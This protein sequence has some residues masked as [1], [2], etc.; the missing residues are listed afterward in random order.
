MQRRV[1]TRVLDNDRGVLRFQVRHENPDAQQR[2]S[3]NYIHIYIYIYIYIYIFLLHLLFGLATSGFTRG[4][5]NLI[6]F[7]LDQIEFFCCFF[8]TLSF[9][10]SHSFLVLATRLTAPRKRACLCLKCCL[11]NVSCRAK[12]KSLTISVRVH[13]SLV[14]T[15]GNELEISYLVIHEYFDKYLY[16]NDIALMKVRAFPLARLLLCVFSLCELVALVEL[17]AEKPRGV[18]REAAPHRIARKAGRK[19]PGWNALHRDWLETYSGKQRIARDSDLPT[20]ESYKRELGIRARKATFYCPDIATVRSGHRNPPF[21]PSSLMPFRD[22]IFTANPVALGCSEQSSQARVRER[23]RLARD[24][25]QSHV[26]GKSTTKRRRET[27]K[28]G[29]SAW[30]PAGVTVARE[31]RGEKCRRKN[32][33][34]SR[35]KFAEYQIG[36]I[37]QQE[38]T[39]G[40][41]CGDHESRYVRVG[42][43]KVQA[44]V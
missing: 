13:T 16:F 18:R 2:A 39:R 27:R 11:A 28:L 25:I 31:R 7:Y 30:T 41:R 8:L 43:A 21:V 34:T 23:Q 1:H 44:A 4:I 15:G 38:S 26:R 37:H 29:R 32:L 33:A 6:M 9:Q 42:D 10:F 22:E 35:A 36:R 3:A 20:S 5:S 40:G 12:N 24:V 19:A 17:A 14:S